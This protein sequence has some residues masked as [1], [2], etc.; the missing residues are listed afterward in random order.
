LPAKDRFHDHVVT[1]LE[2]AGWTITHEQVAV[3]LEKR[4]LWIDIRAVKDDEDLI[5]LVEV[6]G[7]ENMPSPIDYLADAVGKYVL[8]RSSLD[9]LGIETPLYMAVPTAAYEGILSERV[10]QE[11]LQRANVQLIVFDPL[12]REIVQW[13]P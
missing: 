9:Y 5:A 2:R 1:A 4:R 8:Y 13:N 10:G 3:V 12:L 6:K 11:A 7:F